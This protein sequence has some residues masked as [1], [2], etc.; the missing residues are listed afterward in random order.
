MTRGPSLACH[1]QS[2]AYRIMRDDI[3][4]AHPSSTILLIRISAARAVS[5]AWAVAAA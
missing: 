1:I 3:V 2:L 5:C 4:G